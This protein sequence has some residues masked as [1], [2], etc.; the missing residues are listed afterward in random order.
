MRSKPDTV[1]ATPKAMLAYLRS[2]KNNANDPWGGYA[3]VIAFARER[4]EQV[5]AA[6]PPIFDDLE[7]Y[8]SF[9]V[10][11]HSEGWYVESVV[12]EANIAEKA[13]AQGRP[14]EAVACAMRI[15]ELLTEARMKRLWEPAALTGL[16]QRNKLD[17]QRAKAIEAKQT[18]AEKNRTLWQAEADQV[19]A[20][21]PNLS[22]R[23]AGRRVAERLRKRGVQANADTIR[24]VIRKLA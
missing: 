15:G 4:L 17:E 20:E 7:G 22:R 13:V 10:E 12:I 21:N 1:P 6:A 24:R 3:D 18:E 9:F 23:S 16:K 19:W 8:N 5:K 2:I 11:R 14:W